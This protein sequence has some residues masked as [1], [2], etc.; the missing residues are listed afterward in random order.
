[1]VGSLVCSKALLLKNNAFAPSFINIVFKDLFEKGIHNFLDMFIDQ[2]FP[3]F[4]Q[5]QEKA[6]KDDL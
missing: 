3:T 4:E 6:P 1:M 5:V 2:V